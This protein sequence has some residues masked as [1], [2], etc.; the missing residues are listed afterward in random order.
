MA[1]VISVTNKGKEALIFESFK[2]RK[3]HISQ[4]GEIRW[5]C[6]IT[7]CAAT[8]YTVTSDRTAVIRTALD[9][10]H[11]KNEKKLIRQLVTQSAK[12]K[13]VEDHSLKPAK[14]IRLSVKSVQGAEDIVTEEDVKSVRRSCNYARRSSL[15]SLPKSRNEVQLALNSIDTKTTRGEDFLLV[16]DFSKNIVIFSCKSNLRFLCDAGLLYMDGTF[17]YCTKYFEQMFTI[18]GL[19]NGHYIPLVFCLLPNKLTLT[20]MNL[21][22]LLKEKCSEIGI[23]LKPTMITIDFEYG[24][25]TAVA[26]EFP[27]TKISGCRF[28]LQQAWWRKIQKLGLS[29]EYK[30]PNSLIGK[31]L[32]YSFGLTY[33]KPKDVGD[34]YAFDFTEEMPE[35]VG[36]KKFY[37]YLVENYIDEQ[38]VFPPDIWA[39]NSTNFSKTTNSCESFH[40]RFNSSFY[41]PHPSLFIFV[42]VLKDFQFD[43]YIK[44]QSVSENVPMKGKL[45]R[46]E[47]TL[48]E[49]IN[50]VNNG[51]ISRFHFVKC[52]SH[53]TKFSN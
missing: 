15:P 4:E 40:S 51:L 42:S 21:F 12:R 11:E 23:V 16:N 13:A 28:H 14:I 39:E 30:N 48:N 32:R 25:H 44:M 2:Y 52:V 29:T 18:H 7:G 33:L 19:K 45:Y 38:S 34:C 20:Y 50:K 53:Y 3:A 35:H 8:V 5:R 6:T 31:W 17:E 1:G 26:Q 37:D 47:K 10:T 22:K 9:H 49:L 46:K 24:I 36:L 41:S 27:G 43:T